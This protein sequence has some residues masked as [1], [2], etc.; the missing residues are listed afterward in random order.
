MKGK[1]MNRIKV[2]GLGGIGGMLIG[3]L[4]RF[5]QFSG[6]AF[7]V[8]LID[9]DR[10]EQSNSNRQ[11]V[12][13]AGVGRYKAEVWQRRMQTEFK[14]SISSIN[15]YVTPDNIRLLLGEGDTVLL[16]VDNHATR[17]LVQEQCEMLRD[18]VLISGGNDYYDGNI[19]LFIKRSGRQLCAPITRYHPEIADPK[20]KRPDELGCDEEVESKP[21]LLFANMTAACLMLNAFYTIQTGKVDYAEVYFDIRC[22]TASAK[23]RKVI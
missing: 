12:G 1:V 20:D 5:L 9:G 16:C 15:E 11:E 21:Q 2:I 3:P 19:Q 18:I 17:K 23:Q 22:N 8:V 13:L 4:C 10:F 7:E 6:E 14:L